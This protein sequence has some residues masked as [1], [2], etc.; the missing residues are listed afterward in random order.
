MKIDYGRPRLHEVLEDALKDNQFRTI[1]ALCEG[2]CSEIGVRVSFVRCRYNSVNPSILG[3]NR[4]YTIGINNT[5]L[6]TMMEQ[7]SIAIAFIEADRWCPGY[8][9]AHIIDDDLLIDCF[10]WEQAA[11]LRKIIHQFVENA[12]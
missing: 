5:E 11:V 8:L 2:A 1:R 9:R 12:A 3:A 6:D 10:L 4:C 7:F